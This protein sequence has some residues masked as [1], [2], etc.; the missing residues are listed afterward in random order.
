MKL[1]IHGNSL[2]LRLSRAEV[3]Q[4]AE[5]GRVENASECGPRAKLTYSLETASG[6]AE[7]RAAFDN[8]SIRIEAPAGVAREWAATD[9]VDMA[10]QQ[11]LA[12]G[13]QLSVLIEKDFQC[14]HKEGDEDAD[15]FPNPLAAAN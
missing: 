15:A 4:L 10:G 6:V 11:P 3:A 2:R 13:L 5:T 1:R 14:I 9:R 8:G 12:A 7:G